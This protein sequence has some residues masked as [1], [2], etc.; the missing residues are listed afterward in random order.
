MKIIQF[1]KVTLFGLLFLL[2]SCQGI[3]T[4]GASQATDSPV[5][6]Q[7]S[8]TSSPTISNNATPNSI[9]P[10]IEPDLSSR[11][12]PK[13][14]L[15][16]VPAS[17]ISSD[18]YLWNFEIGNQKPL[19]ES[20]IVP[21]FG[22]GFTVSPNGKW[23]AYSTQDGN[24]GDIFL[25]VA[26]SEG[27]P[28]ATFPWKDD[29]DGVSHW[30]DNENLAIIEQV[31][32]PDIWLPYVQQV[33]NPFTGK[34]KTLPANF[35]EPYDVNPNLEWQNQGLAVYNPTL[36]S[37]AYA[38][39]PADIVLMDVQAKKITYRIS[40]VAI[41]ESIPRWAPDGK[42]FVISTR[43]LTD[44]E[45]QNS[46]LYLI[47][48]DK[49]PELKTGTPFFE[50]TESSGDYDWGQLTHF[51][52]SYKR[53]S[54]LYYDWSPNGRYIAMWLMEDF[55][56]YDYDRAILKILDTTTLD[57][58]DYCLTSTIYTGLGYIPLVWA[59]DSK[60]LVVETADDKDPKYSIVVLIDIQDHWV[61]KIAE[62][63][64]PV[65]WMVAP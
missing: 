16:M 49:Q 21:G 58:Q 42:H 26:N 61:T 5:L 22:S 54:I 11:Q 6:P 55:K 10:E 41:A 28:V 46:E 52:K 51:G 20:R 18:A 14:S 43:D 27:Q 15:V 29:W 1:R 57:V 48:P 2:V 25:K 12:R 30:L 64:S 23:L 31:K 47:G 65:G 59:S 13:G 56:Q 24:K 60:Q 53:A 38:G 7:G 33:F 8:S 50:I 37:V 62:N 35:P 4:P 45:N 3:A 32:T 40:G 36:T 63:V 39:W 34:I 19:V 9:C 44:S 17:T